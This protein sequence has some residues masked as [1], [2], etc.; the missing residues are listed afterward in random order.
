MPGLHLAVW[1]GLGALPWTPSK[2]LQAA[3]NSVEQGWWPGE[4]RSPER[5]PFAAVV[6]AEAGG[7]EAGGAVAP[8]YD[9]HYA[10]AAAVQVRSCAPDCG[11]AMEAVR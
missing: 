10:T 3:V 5:G 8:D 4:L 9:E 1:A 6:G 2:M 11:W 7:A